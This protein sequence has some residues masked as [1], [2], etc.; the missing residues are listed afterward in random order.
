MTRDM[1]VDYVAR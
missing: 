1:L